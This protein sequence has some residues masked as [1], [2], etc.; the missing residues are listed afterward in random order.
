MLAERAK[1]FADALKGLSI[2]DVWSRVIIQWGP[3]RRLSTGHREFAG[4]R[5][6]IDVC[7]TTPR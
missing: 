4:Q 6:G 7:E 5:L 3:A 1:R 2:A